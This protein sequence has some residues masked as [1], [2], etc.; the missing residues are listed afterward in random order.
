MALEVLDI[1]RKEQSWTQIWNTKLSL[2]NKGPECSIITFKVDM[3]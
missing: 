2:Y 1:D 3:W